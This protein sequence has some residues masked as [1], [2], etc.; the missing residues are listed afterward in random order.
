MLHIRLIFVR[1]DG[2][3]FAVCKRGSWRP[4]MITSSWSHA[5]EMAG[6]A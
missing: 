3:V 6:V 2:W 4:L 5:R 1:Y